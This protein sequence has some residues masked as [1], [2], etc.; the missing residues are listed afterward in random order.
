[1][2]DVE[3]RPTVE[4][5]EAVL[6]LLAADANT[7]LLDGESLA[8]GL[9]DAGW[10]PEVESGRFSAEGWDLLS[11]A[12]APSVSVFFDGDTASVR[13]RALA[14]AS[15]LRAMTTEFR[16]E[17]PDWSTWTVDDKRWN[18]E[19]I[20][21]LQGAGRGVVVS[22]YTAG[23]T[24]LGPHSLP[25][26]L[27]LS[28]ARADTPSEGLP[29]DDDRSRRVLREGSVI[30]RWFLAGERELPDDVIAALEDDPDSRVRAAADSERWYRERTIDGPPPVS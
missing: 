14:V 17:G 23:E 25:A 2:S 26:H 8:A 19:E 22:L 12:W 10:T 3:R 6:A 29:R 11:S 15:A 5:P 21:W 13:E 24:S 27:H 9:T 16:T 18:T 28:I 4:L 30:D 7:L 1:M 20:D